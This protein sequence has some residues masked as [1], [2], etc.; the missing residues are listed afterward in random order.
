VLQ[1]QALQGQVNVSK[2]VFNR[3]F[4]LVAPHL[5]IFA[6][7]SSPSSL[8][9]NAPFDN[10]SSRLLEQTDNDDEQS[11]CYLHSSARS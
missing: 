9:G 3:I 8:R 11:H 5:S 7:F 4:L 10:T 6:R 2:F 1:A